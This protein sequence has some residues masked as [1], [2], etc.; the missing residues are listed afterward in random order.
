[1]GHNEKERCQVA[2]S[3][4]TSCVGKIA[5]LPDIT[6]QTGSELEQ[7]MHQL[8]PLSVAMELSVSH[9]DGN[10]LQLSAPLGPNINHQMT[11]F[12]GSLLSGCALVGWGLLQLQLGHM[13]RTGNVVVGEATS[14]FYAPVAD[15]LRVESELPPHFDGFKQDLLAKG[16]KSVQLDAHVF[17]GHAKQPAM[18]VSAKYVV[19]LQSHDRT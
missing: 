12:G 8:I 9:Y 7:C 16:V 15:F 4:L 13:G 3:I 19:R 10:K 6:I 2:R 1:M 14:T 5:V 18:T 11:A 17:D